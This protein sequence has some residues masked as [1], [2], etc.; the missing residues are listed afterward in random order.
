MFLSV[1]AG[2]GGIKVPGAPG[3]LSLAAGS[4]ATTAINLS[5]SAPS[6]TG[7]GT[8][9]GYRIKMDGSVIV[10]DTGSTG[11]TYS[12]TGLTGATSYNFNVAAINEKGTGADGNTP[13][14][15]TATPFTATGGTENTY[16]GYKSHTFT[17]TGTFT[18]TGGSQ[19]VDVF[20]LSGGGGGGGPGSLAFTGG[21]GGGG[22][23]YRLT[24]FAASTTS[25]TGSGA[26]HAVTVGGGGSYSSTNNGYTGGTSE[27]TPQ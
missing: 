16:G 11:T 24:T 8:V 26:G 2:Q 1:V 10:A 18:V 22:G 15:T 3:T 5:W 21:G 14:L 25:G 20:V 17:S 12:K 6:D 23:A 7:G 9:S 27:F 19:T 13:S 4:P